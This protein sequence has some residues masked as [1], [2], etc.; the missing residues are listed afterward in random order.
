M[1][2]QCRDDRV[3]PNCTVLLN[4][5][6]ARQGTPVGIS[7][8]A[9]K[10]VCFE[11][12]A[13]QPKNYENVTTTLFIKKDGT[14]RNR[15]KRNTKNMCAGSCDC[16]EFFAPECWCFVNGHAIAMNQSMHSHSLFTRL[17]FCRSMHNSTANGILERWLTQF[18]KLYASPYARARLH[19]QSTLDHFNF[20][21]PNRTVSYRAVSSWV[22]YC[23]C[24]HFRGSL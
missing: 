21:W 1:A 15:T 14:Q 8:Q 12:R 9:F 11:H 20:S 22:H 19:Q 24:Y 16:G 2:V 6:S 23:Y 4:F 13:N 7:V 18:S 17:A 5:T 3:K 10:F